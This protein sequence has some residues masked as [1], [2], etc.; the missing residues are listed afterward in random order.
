MDF[1]LADLKHAAAGTGIDQPPAIDVLALLDAS[2]SAADAKE[3]NAAP[4]PRPQPAPVGSLTPRAAHIAPAEPVEGLPRTHWP[5]F[6]RLTTRLE[7]GRARV[8]KV[9]D[10]ARNRGKTAV[11][12]NLPYSH[13]NLC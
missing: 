4:R 6:D 7:E 9:A 8:S 12:A 2:V 13:Q 11:H 1:S 3:R 5:W 10:N